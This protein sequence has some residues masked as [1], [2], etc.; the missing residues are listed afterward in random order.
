MSKSK[1][2]VVVLVV[3]G[4]VAVGCVVGRFVRP[5][6][7]WNLLIILSTMAFGVGLV[8]TVVQAVLAPRN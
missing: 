8:L 1:G 2:S 5:W 6:E 7:W 4:L 3:L